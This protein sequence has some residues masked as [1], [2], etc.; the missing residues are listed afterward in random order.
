MGEE[1]VKKQ[2]EQNLVNAVEAQRSAI[3]SRSSVDAVWASQ[4]PSSQ[5]ATR[6]FLESMSTAWGKFADGITLDLGRLPQE[7][8]RL[9]ADPGPSPDVATLFDLEAATVNALQNIE[10]RLVALEKSIQTP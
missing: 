4:L 9:A 5:S 2:L 7:A 6:E 1:H 3:R 8:D 10:D